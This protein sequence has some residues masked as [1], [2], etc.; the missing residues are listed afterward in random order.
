MTGDDAIIP[1]SRWR[2]ALARARRGRRADAL[3]EEPDAAKLVPQLPI[4]ELYYA[5]KEVGI[6]D[7]QEL[8]ALASPEQVRGFVDLDA[9]ERDH[10]DEARMREWMNA[11]VEAGPGRLKAAVEALDAEAVAL[12]IQRQARVYDLTLD[13]PLPEEPEGHF[14]PTPDRFFL[15]DV[16][17]G[18]EEGKAFDRML[19]WLYRADL[20]FARRVVMSAKWELPSDLEEHAYRWRTG[21]MSDL[22]YV[23]F[24]EALSIYRYLDPASVKVDEGTAQAVS[25][26]HG[27]VPDAAH[28]LP[29]QLAGAVDTG[30]FFARALGTIL[31]EAEIERLQHLLMLLVNKAMA[32]DLVEPGD[33]ERAQKTLDQTVGYLGIGLEYLSRGDLQRA[34]Q[35]LRSVALERV[36]RVGVSLTLQ[37]RKLA[38]TLAGPKGAGVV[39]LD[40]PYDALVDGLRRPRP[41]LEGRPFHT[42]EDIRKAATTLEEIAQMA[43]YAFSLLGLTPQTLAEAVSA[44]TTRA[45]DVKLGTLVRTWAANVLLDRPPSP[46]PLHPRDL[47]RLGALEAADR[48][49][50]ARAHK[51]PPSALEIRWM[52][53]WLRPFPN[54]VLVRYSW[55]K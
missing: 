42:L 27:E 54:S 40:A 8:V 21:R 50:L 55:L 14:Y 7:A 28:A 51:R 3:L 2:A 47:K 44:S 1:L 12:F 48:D 18:G 16:L 46:A 43:P 52:E 35:A 38:Q 34:A 31:I 37:L 53:D 29:A 19:D 6:A 20:E 10:L 22:G 30:S 25:A 13:E 5:I 24:Y 49:K 32:A 11:L 23:D 17:V 36:F 9:W 26:G 15:L 33:V 41:Q 45:A 4:Q 39:L